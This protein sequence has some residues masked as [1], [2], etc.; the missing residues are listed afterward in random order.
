MHLGPSCPDC[1]FSVELGNTEINTGIR[2]V[3][4]YGADPNFGPSLILLR[5]RVDNLWVSLLGLTF[6]Y[7]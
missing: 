4:A 6:S 7:L 3:L 1:P 2:G 5:E